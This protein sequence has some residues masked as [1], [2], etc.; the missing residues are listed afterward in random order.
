MAFPNNSDKLYSISKNEIV[1]LAFALLLLIISLFLNLGKQP[2]YMEE[3]KRALV[4]LEMIFNNNFWVPTEF[5]EPYFNKPPLYNWVIIGAYKLFGNYSEFSTRFFSVLS[6]LLTGLMFFLIGKK[7]AGIRFA[8]LSSLLF[9]VS[10]DIYYYFSL[11]G[12]IDLFY[13]LIIFCCI[14]SIFHFYEKRKYFHLFITAYFFCAVGTLTKSIPSILFLEISLFV[15]FIYKKDLKKLISFPHF[16]GI[17]IY[18]II[19]GGYLYIYSKFNSLEEYMT[20]LWLD[21]EKRTIL[22]NQGLRSFSHFFVFPLETLKNILPG[23]LLILFCFRKNIIKIIQANKFIEFSFYILISNFII[24]WLSPGA[25][26]RYIYVLY[27]FLIAIL[28][29]P[30]ILNNAKISLSKILNCIITFTLLAGFIGCLLLPFISPFSETPY[31]LFT[32]IVSCLL[33]ILLIVFHL[34]RKI[35]PMFLLIGMFIIMRIVFDLTILPIRANDDFASIRKMNGLAIS[36]II[37]D[38][39][40]YIYQNSHVSNG[41][42]YYVVRETHSIVEREYDIFQNAYYIIEDTYFDDLT[43]QTFYEF[44]FRDSN[45]K[46]IRFDIKNPI[47]D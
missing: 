33:T 24:Y 36:D 37:K 28:T 35:N 13:T 47:P 10:V 46:L 25:K 34:K 30:Y 1:F 6:F 31:I 23:T 43:Y 45:F 5:G 40:L 9:L 15:F 44:K 20:G 4:A 18:F 32:S 22:G 27:P 42:I 41:M 7:Y 8:L 21:S 39:P 38:E 29:Y 14:V 19:I 11:I 3:Q 16:T 12:E 17:I 26:Q 2:I